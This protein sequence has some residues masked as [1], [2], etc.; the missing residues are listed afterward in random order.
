MDLSSILKNIDSNIL[1]EETATAIAEAFKSAVEEKV[2]SRVTL[3]LESALSKQ[4]EDHALKLENLLEAIDTDHSAKLETVVKAINESHTGKLAKLVEYYRGALNEKAE[5]FSNKVVEELSNFIDLY[6]EKAI[7][8][9]QLEEAVSNTT[10]KQQL[11]QIK[12]ILSF[13]PS[14]LNEDVKSLISQGKSKIDEL[15]TQL[16]E[17][18]KENL[19]LSEQL[20]HAKSSLLIEEKTKGMRSAKKNFIT[21]ILSDK[22]PEYISENFN[23]VVEMFEREDKETAASLVEE[24]KESSISKGAKVPVATVVSESAKTEVNSP[25]SGYL[26]ALKEA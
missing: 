15:Q 12:Q 19:T 23:Y 2:S 8:Q 10:A 25:V 14:S 3:E 17:S 21:K 18:Y 11:E 24:A 7:P 16:S 20:T 26:T 1:N 6:I 13:D 9:T 4:D 5:S 22:N